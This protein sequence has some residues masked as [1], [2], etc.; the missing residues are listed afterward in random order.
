MNT[1][2]HLA[3]VGTKTVLKNVRVFAERLR[4]LAATCPL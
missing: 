1:P 2:F 4:P 3:L